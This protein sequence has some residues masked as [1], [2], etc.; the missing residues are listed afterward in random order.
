MLG[1]VSAGIVGLDP[2]LRVNLPNRSASLLLGLDMEREIGRPM[3]EI[4]P[5]FAGLLAQAGAARTAEIRVGPPNARRTLMA[6]LSPEMDGQGHVLTFDDFS[7]V[8]TAQRQAAWADVARRIAHE[9]K[10][11]LTPIQLSAERLKKR[12]LKQIT[13][14]PETFT[15]CTDTI[16][17][18]VGDIGRMVDE[19]SAFARMPQPVIRP[20]EMSR[21]VREALVLQQQSRPDIQWSTD[22][23][24][25]PVHAACDRRLINQALT[26]LLNNAADA[27][28]MRAQR[29][30]E[31]TAGHIRAGLRV[32]GDR[33]I[34]FVEDDG[35]GLPDGDERD[36][37][38]EPYVTHK[39]K[40]TGLGLAIVK[41][42]MEDHRGSIQLS[43]APS[44][45]GTIAE[46]ILPARDANGM[47][48][49]ALE[50]EFGGRARAT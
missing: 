38:T 21:L 28:A 50:R 14:D 35:I 10:N 48:E 15:A 9:I 6:R 5:E 30:G 43:D 49:H 23:P 19:F 39:T 46:L 29:D 18:Q 11:P 32:D 44:G 26:N 17:R 2:D 4:A 27:I 45:Q 47:S 31:A 36:R 37:L 20:E 33:L 24:T 3:A 7:A 42:I 22:L 41:K 1:G 12:Y 13:D 40:G 8:L 34:L 25:E 16:V